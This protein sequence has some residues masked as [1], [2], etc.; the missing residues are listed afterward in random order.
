MSTQ[1]HWQAAPQVHELVSPVPSIAQASDSTAWS[2]QQATA[3]TVNDLPTL[4]RHLQL[5]TEQL[6]SLCATSNF[7]LKVP[8]PFVAR[9]EKRNYNDPLLLQVLPLKA[10]LD[11]VEGYVSDPLEEQNS[12]PCAGII[13]KYKGRVLLTAASSCPVN[14]RYCFRRH[15]PYQENRITPSNW[16]EAINYIAAQ[17]DISEVILS[18][19]EPLLLND[20]TFGKLLDALEPITHV[21]LLRIHTRFPVVVPQ[22]ITPQLCARLKQSRFHTS[23]VLHCNHANELNK[24]V[25]TCLAPLKAADV[26]LLSQSVLLKN[27]NDNL[28][29]LQT[30]SYKLFSMGILPYYLHATDPVAGTAH[31]NVSDTT[32]KTLV[33]DMQNSMPGYLVPQLVREIA[34]RAAKTRL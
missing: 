10:E 30:L 9:M 17:N 8:L 15:F 33:N 19:G 14:C 5:N 1:A 21:K 28:P 34:G 13:H 12:N 23:M 6:R 4:A 31:F 11:N 24:F 32:A 29:T 3:N 25:K 20:K 26:T 16:H 2:W 18:G 7:S 27:I 22:R